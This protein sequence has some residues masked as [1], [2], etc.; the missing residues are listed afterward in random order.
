MPPGVRLNLLLGD[1][2]A[3][4]ETE[5]GDRSGESDLRRGRG[6]GLVIFPSSVR[7]LALPVLKGKCVNFGNS[8]GAGDD[9][10]SYLLMRWVFLENAWQL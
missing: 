8:N 10:Y 9:H 2:K 5:L 4:I 3:G 7:A 6:D 1:G